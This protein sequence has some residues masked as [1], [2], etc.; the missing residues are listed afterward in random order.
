[1]KEDWRIRGIDT[2]GFWNGINVLKIVE[3]E[4][5]LAFIAT[6]KPEYSVAELIDEIVVVLLDVLDDTPA[7]L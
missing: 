6:I 5:P 7:I 2:A 4:E 1:M 3:N